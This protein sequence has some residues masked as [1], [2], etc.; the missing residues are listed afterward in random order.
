MSLVV[1]TTINEVD[2]R[3]HREVRRLNDFADASKLKIDERKK[4]TNDNIFIDFTLTLSTTPFDFIKSNNFIRKSRP[5]NAV[6][7]FSFSFSNE[8]LFFLFQR[9]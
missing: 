8:F 7:M 4:K 5:D 1:S 6:V 2:H 9:F 3:F